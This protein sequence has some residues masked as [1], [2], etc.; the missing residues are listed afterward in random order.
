[1]QTA[2]DRLGMAVE[3]FE[4]RPDNPVSDILPAIERAKV[5]A[6]TFFPTQTV[7]ANAERIAAW[8][9]KVRLPTISGWAQF[10]QNGNLMSYGPNLK[11]TSRRLAFFTDRIL[12]GARPGDLP[13]ELPNEVE[14]VINQKTAKALGVTIPR[15][16]LVRANQVIQ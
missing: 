9:A 11:A 12:K 14:L 6:A 8:S 15:A 7:I 2:A 10:P 1:M 4:I 13:V 3:Y 5:Q 16:V